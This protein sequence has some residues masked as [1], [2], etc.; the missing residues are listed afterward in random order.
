L[1]RPTR[2]R[3]LRSLPALTRLSRRSLLARVESFA[4]NAP[5]QTRSPP[6]EGGRCLSR[7]GIDRS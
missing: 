4:E 7:D 1:T 6:V 2:R 3:L 5:P